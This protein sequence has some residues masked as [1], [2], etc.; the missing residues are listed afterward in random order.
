MVNDVVVSLIIV[1]VHFTITACEEGTT[2]LVG[3]REDTEGTVEI[4]YFNL[5]GLV[6][7]FGWNDAD[8]SVV[9]YELG[10]SR[11]GKC[12]QWYYDVTLT[13]YVVSQVLLV[14]LIHDMVNPIKQF[15]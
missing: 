12:Q 5:W 9:C 2:R 11:D 1:N 4:C 6:S 15:I 7:V 10:Y 14:L 13:L 3:G 8:A